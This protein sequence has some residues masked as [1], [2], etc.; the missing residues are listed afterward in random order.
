[1]KVI[2]QNDRLTETR[3]IVE[4]FVEFLPLAEREHALVQ[5]EQRRIIVGRSV[6]A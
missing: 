6:A 5:F 1:M 2:L 4:Q 3:V